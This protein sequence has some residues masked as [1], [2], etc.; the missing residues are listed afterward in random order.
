[1][2]GSSLSWSAVSRPPERAPAS[3]LSR[4]H[5]DLLRHGTRNFVADRQCPCAVHS[6]RQE[7]QVRPNDLQVV[8]AQ[9]QEG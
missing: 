7:T 5:R 3:H 4:L 2:T 8:R 1:M 9:V 6:T